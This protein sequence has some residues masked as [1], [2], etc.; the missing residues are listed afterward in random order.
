MLG[1]STRALES[2]FRDTIAN[3]KLTVLPGDGIG[4]SFVNVRPR[5]VVTRITKCVLS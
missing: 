5:R 3:M 4:D 1:Y 2:F